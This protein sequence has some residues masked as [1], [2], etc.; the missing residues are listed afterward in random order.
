MQT[1][2]L[3]IKRHLQTASMMHHGLTTD[4]SRELAYQ[5]AKK[6]QLKTPGTWDD[7]KPAG[8][9]WLH[10]FLQRCHKLA[11]HA[12]KDNIMVRCKFWIERESFIYNKTPEQEHACTN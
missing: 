10:G 6:N 8:I 5:F 3:K 9:D 4:A 11:R 7:N 1:F 12:N 2:S